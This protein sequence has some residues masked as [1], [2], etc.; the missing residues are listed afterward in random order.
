[1]STI[2]LAEYVEGVPNICGSEELL[3]RA[4]APAVAADGGGAAGRRRRR[5]AGRTIHRVDAAGVERQAGARARVW[6]APGHLDAS[7]ARRAGRWRAGGLGGRSGCM[8]L[9]WAGAPIR[10]Q[11][12]GRAGTAGGR[13]CCRRAGGPGGSL[14]GGW[15][16]CHA[17]GFI[18]DD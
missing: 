6:A 13:A 5:M 1:M 16:G 14:L 4:S 18:A 7:M 9:A 2:S 3:A 17:R 10:A 12:G 8:R 15:R 11:A